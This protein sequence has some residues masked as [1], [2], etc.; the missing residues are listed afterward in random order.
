MQGEE[1]SRTQILRLVYKRVEYN[2]DKTLS[3]GLLGEDVRVAFYTVTP[4]SLILQ[5][6]E[7]AEA[8]RLKDMRDLRIAGAPYTSYCRWHNGPLSMPDKPWER[9]YCNVPSDSYCKQHKRSLRHLY[10]L[11]STLHGP[12]GLEACKAVDR[13]ERAEYAVYLT[14]WGGGKPKVGMTRLFRLYERIAEQAHIT[15]TLLAITDSAYKARSLEMLISKSGLAQE[16]KRQS[17]RLRRSLGESALILKRWAEKIAST[18]GVEWDGTLFTVRPASI[19]PKSFRPVR[20]PS[21]LEI[22]DINGYWAGYVFATTP[23]EAKIAF[24]VKPL[25]HKASIIIVGRTPG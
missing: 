22:A 24:Q 4:D 15:A 7:Y 13:I 2:G 14:D 20:D 8:Y 5:D 23:E 10:E 1:S 17:L 3:A 21:G 19:D 25:Q 12:K 11:C 9:I 18:A 6:P 16:Q